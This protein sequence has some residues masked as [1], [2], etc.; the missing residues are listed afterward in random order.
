MKNIKIKT[1]YLWEVENLFGMI[2]RASTGRLAVLQFE[3]GR[4]CEL[5]CFP[6]R[7]TGFWSR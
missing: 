7:F 2:V 5:G 6:C 4:H 1:V 3:L